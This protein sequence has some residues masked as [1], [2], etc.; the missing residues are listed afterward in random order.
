MAELIT[1]FCNG[2]GGYDMTLGII[3]VVCP[4][5]YLIMEIE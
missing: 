3:L 1:E 2:V 5:A 4:I